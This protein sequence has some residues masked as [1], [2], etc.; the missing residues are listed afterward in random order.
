[1]DADQE[2]LAVRTSSCRR[3]VY[4]LCLEQRSIWGRTHRISCVDQINELPALKKA[5][6]FLKDVPSHCLQQGVRDL[7]DAFENFWSGRSDYPTYCRKSGG[8]SFRFPDSKQFLCG[9]T[10]IFLPKLGHVEWV[11]HRKMEGTP[12]SVTVV[13][14]GNW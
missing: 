3:L 6:P 5:F 10:S 14:E 2:A 13:R 4:N 1:M 9:K 11:L 12:K 7:Q 8:D